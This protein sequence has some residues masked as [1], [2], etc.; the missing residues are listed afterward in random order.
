VP[1]VIFRYGLVFLDE[2]HLQ[3]FEA[4]TPG[5]LREDIE[6]VPTV[7][8][9]TMN[10]HLRAKAACHLEPESREIKWYDILADDY[11]S[12]TRAAIYWAFTLWSGRNWGGWEDD[13]GT[14]LPVVDAASGAYSMD[15]ISRLV[16]LVATGYRWGL[17]GFLPPLAKRRPAAMKE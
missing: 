17:Q 7:Y 8:M 4:V 15:K 2:L 6:W 13:D 1:E 12:G 9:L 5:K 10:E 11:G 3:A 16:A 14:V